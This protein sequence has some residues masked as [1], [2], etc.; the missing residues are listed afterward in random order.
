[1][2]AASHAYYREY[3]DRAEGRVPRKLAT[4]YWD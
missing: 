4:T 3:I 2:V 1:M